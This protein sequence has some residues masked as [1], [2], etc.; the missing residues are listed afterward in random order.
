MAGRF[1]AEGR[2]ELAALVDDE[3]GV[4]VVGDGAE[5]A[6]LEREIAERELQNVTLLGLRPRAEVPTWIASSDALLVM[7]RDLPVFETVIPS[8]MF[9]FLAQARPVVMAAPRAGECRA[10][11]EGAHGG[12]TGF[13]L[14]HVL[15]LH[16]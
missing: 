5:R 12:Y 3:L 16:I 14:L 9:E 2:G 13:Q 4:Q 10:L 8:K 6:R 11:L 15:Y 7:L 1:E